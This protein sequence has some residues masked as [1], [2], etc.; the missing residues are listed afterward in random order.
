MAVGRTFTG[1]EKL[2]LQGIP[3]DRLKLSGESEVQLGDL[4]GNAMSL[5]VINAAMLS[6]LSVQEYTLRKKK[7]AKYVGC[8]WGGVRGVVYVGWCTLGIR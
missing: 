4:A 8:T 7:S 5:P 3:T 1:G 2:L 6:V